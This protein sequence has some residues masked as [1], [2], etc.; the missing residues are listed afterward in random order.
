LRW[1]SLLQLA[2]AEEEEPEGVIFITGR[3]SILLTVHAI[4]EK[5][6]QSG[7]AACYRFAPQF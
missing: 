3:G 5:Q 7:E 2:R 1:R 4:V 6:R